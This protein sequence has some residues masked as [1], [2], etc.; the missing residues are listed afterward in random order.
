MRSGRAALL[1]VVVA[2]SGFAQ[3]PE[4]KLSRAEALQT[5]VSKVQPQY[6]PMA[7]QLRIEGEVDLEAVVSETG[8][9]EKVNILSGNPVLTKPAA[10]A[11]KK[12]KFKPFM[13]DGKAQRV[14]AP[15]SITF[16][17]P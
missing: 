15:V 13:A 1:L 3:E 4:K 16:K 8:S 12:W 9:V 11:L 2:L 17:R 7:L 5:A 6:P 10:E 14:L